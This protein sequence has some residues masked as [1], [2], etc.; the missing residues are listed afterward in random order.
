MPKQWWIQDFSDRG[1]PIIWQDFCSNCM[2]M[3]EIGLRGACV[4]STPPLDP[5][6]QN[7]KLNWVKELHWVTC[8]Q[9]KFSLF[10]LF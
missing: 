7:A 6:M 1:A 9:E 2:K 3:K 5:P 10:F 4:P 8:T